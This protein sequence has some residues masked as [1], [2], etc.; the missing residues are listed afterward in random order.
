MHFTGTHQNLNF[1]FFTD[2]ILLINLSNKNM[3]NL[4]V[5]DNDSTQAEKGYTT[6][7]YI[8][9]CVYIYLMDI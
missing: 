2:V 5:F 4:Y 7:A 9:K 1:F 6:S 8:Y 3:F